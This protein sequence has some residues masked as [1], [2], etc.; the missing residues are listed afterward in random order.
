M[1]AAV[2]LSCDLLQ[3]VCPSDSSFSQ[4]YLVSNYQAQRVH[5]KL[6]MVQLRFTTA[7]AEDLLQQREQQDQDQQAAQ[8]QQLFEELTLVF[9]LPGQEDKGDFEQLQRFV[10]LIRNVV[11]AA[12]SGSPAPQSVRS[13]GAE[14]GLVAKSLLPSTVVDVNRSADIPAGAALGQQ[15]R[16]SVPVQ[17]EPH[18][19]PAKP[20][21]RP[22]QTGE[23]VFENLAESTV[24]PLTAEQA[25]MVA[26]T[27]VPVSV[28]VPV[29]V[30]VPVPPVDLNSVNSQLL[31]EER[32]RLLEQDE[33]LRSSYEVSK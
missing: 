15:N 26:A 4:S 22:V 33:E 8:Q 7:A 11:A 2:R 29:R 25:K 23:A 20:A 24:S 18:A 5:P 32:K 19:A 17:A 16:I 10:A 1:A 31:A 3:V 6:P 21:R 13:A 9:K 14:L 27:A 28:S 30:R 12:S